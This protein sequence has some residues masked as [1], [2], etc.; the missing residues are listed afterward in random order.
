M[1]SKA[2]PK[3]LQSRINRLA[4]RI[5]IQSESRIKTELSERLLAER[6]SGASVDAL[7]RLLD[8]IEG[9]QATG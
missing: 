5:A 3:Q 7:A 9:Q 8:D 1:N 4:H 6:D 2:L